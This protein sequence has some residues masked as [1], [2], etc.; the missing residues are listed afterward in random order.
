MTAV[1]L[2]APHLTADNYRAVLNDAG[3]RSKREVEQIVAR[4]RPQPAVPASVRKLPVPQTPAASPESTADKSRP[5]PAFPPAV[6]PLGPQRPAAVTPLAPERYKVQFTVSRET[7][8]K[9]RR[10]QD[11][12]RHAIPPGD[13]AEIFDR[14]LTVLL[15]DL[16]QARLASAARPRAGRPPASGF[17]PHPG[18]G[19]EGGLE[20][21][22][23]P[24]RVRWRAWPLHGTRFPRVPPRAAIRSRWAGRRSECRVEVSRTQPARGGEVLWH[25]IAP[26]R[27]RGASTSVCHNSV[28]PD[29]VGRQATARARSRTASS[30]R[31]LS[32]S[33]VVSWVPTC[34]RFARWPR[35]SSPRDLEHILEASPC[36]MRPIV[37]ASSPLYYNS[38]GVPPHAVGSTSAIDSENVQT[39]PPGSSTVYCRSPYG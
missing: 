32:V 25:A 8:D 19:E 33:A 22:W 27:A 24:V 21:R 12:L 3:H 13:P 1:C 15:S 10:T 17:P 38:S 36:P 30:R 2:L 5:D 37:S 9:L 14:A 20:A 39:C 6:M 31:R 29:R 4:L 28:R 34:R 11:L 23:W 16:E 26:T 7:H 18:G 35:A